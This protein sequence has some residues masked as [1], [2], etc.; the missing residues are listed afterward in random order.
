MKKSVCL[1]TL[2]LALLSCRTPARSAALSMKEEVARAMAECA[3]L[4]PDGQKATQAQLIYD[5][6][7]SVAVL[8]CGCSKPE[9]LAPTA[10]NDRTG[11]P[12]EGANTETF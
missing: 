5:R 10:S 4:C 2:L 3:P 9:E 12:T 1:A 6:V 8:N 7:R 11:R